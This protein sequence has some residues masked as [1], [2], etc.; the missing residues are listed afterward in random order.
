MIS[1]QYVDGLEQRIKELTAERDELSARLKTSRRDYE[2]MN[3]LREGAEAERD[4]MSAHVE[5]WEEWLG[6]DPD[7]DTIDW[8][9]EGWSIAKDA[10]ETSL[11]KLKA[12]WQAEVLQYLLDN[13]VSHD[14]EGNA[15]VWREDI[16]HHR[17]EYQRQ[18]TE[19]KA[20]MIKQKYCKGESCN[21]SPTSL[22]HSVE[23]AFE[24]FMAYSGNG[25]NAECLAML[26]LVRELRRQAGGDA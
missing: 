22:E 12:K 2:V 11:A 9:D 4:A 15:C 20:A 1:P 23:C 10:P 25:D 14:W 16:V 5:R 6:S 18:L 3:K 24:H 26:E 17:D 19:G 13:E 8:I 21:A 7:D